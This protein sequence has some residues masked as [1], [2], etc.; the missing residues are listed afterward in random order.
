M[1]QEKDNG[2]R[3]VQ[4]SPEMVHDLT[5]RLNRIEGQVKG[6]RN[7]VE[8]GA[9][10]TDILMQVSAAT[11]ALQAFNR[12]L[13][14]EHMRTCVTQKLKKGDNE[15]IEELIWTLQKMMR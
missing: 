4:R 5:V 3:T 12:E 13:L 14:Y 8:K 1:I 15:I 9:Y 6:I 10:C 11:S 7:M 2:H